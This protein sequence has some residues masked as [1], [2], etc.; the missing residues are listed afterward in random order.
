MTDLRRGQRRLYG[1]PSGLIR[2]PQRSGLGLLHGTDEAV[3]DPLRVDMEAPEKRVWAL[4]AT[5]ET[6]CPPPP[7]WLLGGP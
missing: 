6:V 2:G 3:W 4:D 1:A 7:D 5:E